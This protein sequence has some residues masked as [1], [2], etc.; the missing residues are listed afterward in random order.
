MIRPHSRGAR[1]STRYWFV[2]IILA[3]V[4]LTLLAHF[5]PG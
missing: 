4:G 2:L 5:A 3:W 1:H